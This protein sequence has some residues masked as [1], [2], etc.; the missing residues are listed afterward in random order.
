MKPK[1]SF[2]T[3]DLR[4]HITTPRSCET[5]AI[6]VI[7]L[8]NCEISGLV[9]NNGNLG[10]RNFQAHQAVFAIEQKKNLE[11]GG[12]DLEA[13]KGLTVGACRASGLHGDGTWRQFLWNDH[14]KSL[15]PTL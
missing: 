9:A 2:L 14:G 8:P 7:F 11:I 3:V 4:K 10:I 13:F 6:S 1:G 15:H 12:I 5:H